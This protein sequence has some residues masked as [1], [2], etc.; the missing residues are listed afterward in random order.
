MSGKFMMN[1]IPYLGGGGSGGGNVDDVQV[2]GTSVVDA[3]KIAQITSYKEVTQAQYEALPD[4]KLNDGI[5][6][7][8]KDSN[9]AGGFPPL[10]YS[11]IEREVGVWRDGKPLYQI[12]FHITQNLSSSMTITH[13]ISDFDFCVSVDGSALFGSGDNLYAEPV[14]TGSEMASG[15]GVGIIDVNKTTFGIQVGSTRIS[16]A[17]LT[18]IDVTLKYTKTT[19]TAGSGSW[20]TSGGYAHHY[21]TTEQIVGTWIDGKPLYE[22]SYSKVLPSSHDHDS[23]YSY[24]IDSDVS[25][26]DNLIDANG[27]MNLVALVQH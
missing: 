27:F 23:G 8:I 6:Y 7:A 15:W 9:G 2:N 4:T 11:D 14:C 21:S 19:D 22:K 25:Y 20:A 5:L 26:I 3:N 10:I 24:L 16:T 1:G 12:T 18:A 17:G 13:N